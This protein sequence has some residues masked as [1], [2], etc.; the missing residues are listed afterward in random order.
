MRFRNA[1]NRIV[2]RRYFLSGRIF[3]W[4][5]L[6]DY[7]Y[8]SENVIRSSVGWPL[9]TVSARCI[10]PMRLRFINVDVPRNASEFGGMHAARRI[11]G[12]QV[13]RSADGTLAH[14]LRRLNS[15]KKLTP[16]V[17][18]RGLPAVCRLSK[19]KSDGETLNFNFDNLIISDPF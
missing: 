6:R 18:C 3:C 10:R 12:E 14:A 8:F 13:I 17:T 4:I 15:A 11:C 5:S 16:R 1:R 19:S 7:P 9:A 2:P